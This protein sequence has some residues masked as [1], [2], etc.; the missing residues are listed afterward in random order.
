MTELIQHEGE[1]DSVH[2]IVIDDGILLFKKFKKMVPCCSPSK[3]LGFMEV[4]P[5]H[6]KKTKKTALGVS[7]LVNHQLSLF[8]CAWWYTSHFQT[9]TKFPIHQIHPHFC[10][11]NDSQ[12]ISNKLF[13]A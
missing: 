11:F 10:C 2:S 5:P 3:Q 12:I 9:H 7:K 6:K 4:H 8:N 13:E 1:S